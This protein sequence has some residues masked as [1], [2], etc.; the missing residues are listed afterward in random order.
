MATLSSLAE[1][2]RSEI[3]D[4]GKSFVYQTTADGITNRYL[5]PYSPVDGANLIV[6]VNGIDVSNAA[7]IEEETGYL[8]LDVTPT[9][10]QLI[11][12]AGTYYRYFTN[13]EICNFITDAFNQHTKNHADP[14]GRGVTITNLPG[15]EEYPVVVY[16]ATLSL[17]TL[18]NDAAFDIDIT[19]PDGVQ[20][21][22]SERYRQLM[23][24]TQQRK[25]QYVELCSQLGIGLYKIDVF[26]LR[27]IAKFSNR[28]IPIYLPQEV[29][30]RGMPQRAL[31]PKPTYGAQQF[32]SDVPTFDLTAYQGDSFE[33]T[34]QF[35]FDVTA[36][37]WR[38]EIHMQFG[39]GIPLTAFD[40]AFVDGDTTKLLLTLTGSQTEAL[41]DLCFWDIQAKATD[42]SGYE[43][44]Y[45][46]G[47]MF[48]TRE[49]TV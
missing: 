22:R 16:A 1:R 35:A 2:L 12:V 21:P 26:Q 5:I 36:Y 6:Y 25:A 4:I 27:R 10:G 28:Y 9:A 40:I 17:Y 18:A 48:V 19:A 23:D 15:V 49:A 3:G 30:D 7:L 37:T 45:M 11:I 39:D 44:T 20:I 32:P 47:A 41:P 14:Y 42:D 8:T 24:M 29:D 33:V 43:Q 34:L 46:R 38:S 31:L 13:N